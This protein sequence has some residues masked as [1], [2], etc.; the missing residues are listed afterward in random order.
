MKEESYGCYN[1]W[2]SV[3]SKDVLGLFFVLFEDLFIVDLCKMRKGTP[4]SVF[5]PA[6]LLL[7]SPSLILLYNLGLF[8]PLDRHIGKVFRLNCLL[9]RALLASI[10][11]HP[12]TL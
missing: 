3:Q 5:F 4:A 11:H 9:L 12:V 2:G 1:Q 7:L 6:P 10:H 8:I